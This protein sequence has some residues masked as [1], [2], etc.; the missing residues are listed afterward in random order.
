MRPTS[1]T[2]AAARATSS[3]LIGAP[4]QAMA[5]R[6]SA[7]GRPPRAMLSMKPSRSS[8][9]R[10][11]MRCSP[12]SVFGTASSQIHLLHTSAPRSQP[13]SPFQAFVDTLKEE[14]RK[15]QELQ[16]NMKELQGEA[17]K[18]QDSET[19]K[20]MREAYER[21][22]IITSIKEN[23]RLQKAANQ[24]KKSGGQVG[25]AVG[26][27]LKQME[28]SELIKGVSVPKDSPCAKHRLTKDP[29]CFTARRYFLPSVSPISR[30][31]SSDQK[32]RSIQ[33]ILRYSDR[34]L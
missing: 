10:A 3:S 28:D 17:G 6:P 9:V 16:E 14:L 11:Q 1:A 34:G 27:A 4:R 13:K 15:S 18:I 31:H 29:Y 5:L 30:I 8:I 7:L 2:Q 19:M 21:A 26:A 20:K 22:R 24:L 23:P 25:D 12:A 32:H 33:S